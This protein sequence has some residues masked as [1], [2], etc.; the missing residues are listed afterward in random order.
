MVGSGYAG[1]SGAPALVQGKRAHL[2]QLESEAIHI[3]RECVAESRNPVM[4]FS[5][6][7]D[8]TV[9]AHL[10][11]RAFYPARPPFPLLHVDSTWEFRS[12]LDFR[13]RFAAAH[14]FRLI[15]K[16]NER[17]LAEGINPFDHGE[18]YTS[19]MRTE[20]LKQALDE[21][22][23]DIIFGGARRD[24]EKSRAKERIVSIRNASHAWEP[25]Q[26]RPELLSL[27]NTRL[28]P[29]S[30]ARVFPLS[31]WTEMDVWE[32]AL[33]RNIELCDLYFSA[34]RRVI[35][36]NGALIAVDEPERMR[37]AAGD[38]IE[39]RNV[40]FRT[41]GCWPVTGG[42]ESPAAD[43]AGVIAETIQASTSERQGRMADSE[44]GGSL[45]RKKRE[46]YF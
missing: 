41:L 26:Q 24:E 7:K 28:S 5:G 33:S 10:A 2:D 16:R 35:G 11:L 25:R 17:G 3:M 32:Y 46:G 22:G 38:E 15:V 29:A 13:D 9:M 6:G 4:L 34:P 43:I 23:F 30:T 36:R 1:A 27:Y 42:I 14:G 31:N 8:S 19:L 39:T 37:F 12:V 40:R 18:R 44:E 21:G 45:E 20:P